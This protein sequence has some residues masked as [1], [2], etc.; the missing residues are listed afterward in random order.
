MSSP[1]K[2]IDLILKDLPDIDKLQQIDPDR[3]VGDSLKDD[4]TIVIPVLNEEE[5]IGRVIKE[6]NEDGYHNILVVDGYSTDKTVSIASNNGVKVIYQ[7]G[8]GKTGAIKT[9]VE[10]IESPYFVV[11]DGD[12]TYSSKDIKNV[13]PHIQIYDEVIGIRTSGRENIPLTNRFGNWMINV[14]FNSLF[15]TNLLD[16]CSGMYALRTDFAKELSFRTGGFD[17]EVEIAAQAASQGKLTQVPISYSKRVGK[18]KLSSWKH[19]I[20]IMLSLFKLARIH[21]PIFLYSIFA[22]LSSIPAVF[23]LVWVTGELLYGV[24]HGT[25]ALLGVIFLMVFLQALTISIVS[26]MIRR[27]EQRMLKR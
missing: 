12:C 13:F 21:N 25:L 27:M 20:Q 7:H 17:I 19:G 3:D 6:V 22:S 15:G 4:F 9:A 18:Q 5:G 26:T 11:M 14:F 1:I 23:I 16:V 24:W 10:C 2:V 8:I